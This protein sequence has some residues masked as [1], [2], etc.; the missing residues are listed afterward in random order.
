MEEAPVQEMIP[1]FLA[2]SDSTRLNT[3]VHFF[4]KPGVYYLAYVA[5]AG[6]SI[7]LDLAGD[8]DYKMDIIDTWNMKVTEQRTA[9]PGKLS[10]RT[11]LPYTALRI[12]K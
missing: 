8:A 4:S 6:Q 7:E 3:N 12:Y 9:Q 1:A 2:H 11:E 10:F 5:D